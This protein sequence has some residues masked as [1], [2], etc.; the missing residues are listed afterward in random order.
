VDYLKTLPERHF[1]SGM[2]EVIKCGVIAD[3]DLFRSLETHLDRIERREPDL[4]SRV[5]E[6]CCRIKVR[7]VSDD[8]RESDRRRVLNFGHT[9]AAAS[10][11]LSGSRLARGEAVWGGRVA[12]ARLA[13]RLGLLSLQAV[14]RIVRLCERVGLPTTVPPGFATG[15]IL[16][17]AR[18]DKK[19]RQGR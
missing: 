15:A 13:L 5:I 11:P 3:R 4:M 6:A 14:E 19:N 9:I 2:A 12:A 16:D 18:R 8:P 7:V 10:A 1:A 17:V